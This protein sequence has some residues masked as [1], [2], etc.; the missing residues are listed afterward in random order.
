MHTHGHIYVHTRMYPR[1]RATLSVRSQFTNIGF[2][3]FKEFGLQE[4]RTLRLRIFSIW[5]WRLSCG[6]LPQTSLRS[7]TLTLSHSHTP[8]LLAINI[9]GALS[10][11]T[12]RESQCCAI[13]QNKAEP[14]RQT[15]NNGQWNKHHVLCYGSLEATMTLLTVLLHQSH[16][17][18]TIEPLFESAGTRAL[19]G[20]DHTVSY[21][22]LQVYKMALKSTFCQSSELNTHTIHTKQTKHTHTHT[23]THTH[24]H[25]N[26]HTVLRCLHHHSSHA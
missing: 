22:L 25:R 9:N 18:S 4:S 6:V 26:R 14:V 12:P 7:R 1:P 21:S 11:T 15:V 8:T 5:S 2:Q 3:Y 19:L 20:T 24:R 10:T 13:C 23:Q 16:C 17:Y